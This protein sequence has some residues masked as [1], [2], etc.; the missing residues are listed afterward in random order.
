MFLS[1]VFMIIGIDASR[2][3]LAK[4]TGIEEYSY[5]LIKHLRH[6]LAG[7]RVVLYV[8]A[9]N[10]R[11]QTT[12]SKQSI[13]D[14]I[15]FELPEKWAV[16]ELW[17]PRFWTQGRLAIEMLFHSVDVLFVPAHTVPWIHPKRTVVVVHGLEYEFCPETYSLWERIY[18]RWSIRNSCR[19]ASS[20]IAVSE[21]TKRDLMSRYSMP[22]EKM[23]V[24]YEGVSYLQFPT[25]NEQ[26]DSRPSVSRFPISNPYFLFIGRIE[27]RKNVRRIIAAFDR[28]KKKHGTNHQLVLAGK[29]GFGYEVI[30]DQLKTLPCREDVVEAGYVSE[31]EK[32]RLLRNANGFLFPTLYEGFGLPVLEAQ[33]AGVPVVT[34]N[35]SSLPE[36]SGSDSAILV[37]PLNV[38]EIA[39]GIEKI[40]LDQG[41]RSGIIERGFQNAARFSWEACAREI[42]ELLKL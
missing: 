16:R 5:Q 37:D 7:E 35:V 1:S 6:E 14:G 31:E 29:P 32:W 18:M 10:N 20:I 30:S 27:A 4:R 15:D 19:W 40:A 25:D 34:S 13:T 36:V 41:F 11:Q 28:F 22:E 17:A 42:A 3:F 8:R 12:S 2:A 39:Q 21:N 38:E 9:T 26:S 24:V 33:S 23:R